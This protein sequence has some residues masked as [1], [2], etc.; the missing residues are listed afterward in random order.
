M[1]SRN[2]FEMNAKFLG[3]LGALAVAATTAGCGSAGS[4]AT[5][6]QAPLKIALIPPSGGALARLGADATRGWEYAA[7]EVNAQGGVDGHKVELVKLAT[8]G[9]PAATVRAARKAVSQDGARFISGV[10]TSPEQAALQPQ[11]QG[12]NAVS[13]LG[14]GKDDSLTGESCSPNAFR[15]VLSTSMEI[16]AFRDVLATLP[17]ERWAIQSVDFSTGHTAAADFAQ[18][19]E[20]AGKQ[21]VL[22]QYAPLGTADWGSAISK[23][24]ESGADGLFALV[25]GAD[26][27]GFI[28]Q[29]T[30]F[31]LFDQFKTVFGFQMISEPVFKALGDKILG[32]YSNVG[33]DVSASNPQNRSFVAGYTKQY[34]AAPYGVPADHYLAAQMLFDAVRK[35]K[36]VD[37]QKV[38]AALDNLSFESFAGRVTIGADHQLVRPSYV[39]K[40]VKKGDGLGFDIVAAVPGTG[41]HP[42]PDPACKA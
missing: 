35:A 17:A 26:G 3:A 40:V 36:S 21:V 14:L 32:F 19:A 1:L 28:N 6:S 22:T 5:G 30:Q 13:L 9:T 27:V 23:L 4:S 41:N 31:K 8:D 11:L 42:A 16:A 10:V 15:A 33:Y 39:G 7:A 38:R 29:G 37:P 24:K 12:M 18:A 2:E 25:P 34:G 20:A